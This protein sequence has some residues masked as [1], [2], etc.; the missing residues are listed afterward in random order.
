MSYDGICAKSPL[1]WSRLPAATIR[2]LV[3]KPIPVQLLAFPACPIKI[4]GIEVLR[5]IKC[6]SHP[7]SLVDGVGAYRTIPFL[8]LEMIPMRCRGLGCWSIWH[9]AVAVIVAMV[10][11]RCAA[12]SGIG[13]RLPGQA[14]AAGVA[15]DAQGVLHTKVYFDPGGQLMRER[16]AAAKA[17][18]DP[19]LAVLQQA[20]QGFVESA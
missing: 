10:P 6:R 15:I 4:N 13:G 20:A 19:K 12:S 14:S 16:I 9:L 5:D 2:G 18:L 7:R 11:R 8:E 3:A 1:L 17:T